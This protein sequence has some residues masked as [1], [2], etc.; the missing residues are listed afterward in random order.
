MAPLS[1]ALVEPDW[2]AVVTEVLR[3]APR[4]SLIVLL[5][6]LDASAVQY[7]LLPVLPTL[8]ARHQV[9]LASVA[10]PRIAELARG[11]GDA[12][13]VYGAAAA[14]RARLDR[15]R[16]ATRLG[17][18]GVVVVEGAP[19]DLPPRLADSYIALK[20]AGRL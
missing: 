8:T 11:S 14:E 16:V 10:D 20:A 3:R 1:A 7:G 15:A 13:A 19:E 4:R 5:T 12:E 17:Q 6:A 2:P 9:V 18:A